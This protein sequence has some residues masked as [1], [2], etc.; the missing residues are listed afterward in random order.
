MCD[1]DDDNDT[2]NDVECAVAGG[3]DLNTCDPVATPGDCTALDN[4]HFTANT[5]QNNNDADADGDACDADDD[6]DTVNDVK[7]LTP[8]CDEVTC[9][10]AVLDPVTNEPDCEALDNCQFVENTDQPTATATASAT[11]A[12]TPT[13]TA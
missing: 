5:N 12:S 9:D 13:T 2:V 7:C 3:C 11:P 10:P 8:E 6:D 4:C 1:A